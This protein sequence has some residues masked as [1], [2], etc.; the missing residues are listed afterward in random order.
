MG[1]GG[2]DRERPSHSHGDTHP[3]SAIFYFLKAVRRRIETPVYC[4]PLICQLVQNIFSEMSEPKVAQ[5]GTAEVK[6]QAL[7]RMLPKLRACR[8]VSCP[9]GHVA[10]SNQLGW[11]CDLPKGTLALIFC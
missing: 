7:C 2:A 8:Q 10:G 1:G 3:P 11:P 6:G 9:G 5:Q 4:L